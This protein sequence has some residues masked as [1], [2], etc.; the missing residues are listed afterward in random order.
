MLESTTKKQ[1]CVST[2]LGELIDVKTEH[3]DAA[4]TTA[5]GAHF[6]VHQGTMS[7]FV[8]DYAVHPTT[9]TTTRKAPDTQEL[10]TNVCGNFWLLLLL[11][12]LHSDIRTSTRIQC[13]EVEV[14]VSIW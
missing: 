5:P 12:L 6:M 11:L 1:L 10:Y 8:Y 3:R 13:N 2:C 4:L 9:T 14:R 7:T